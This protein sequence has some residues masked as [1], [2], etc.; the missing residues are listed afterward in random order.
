MRTL[1]IILALVISVNLY[2]QDF[3]ETPETPTRNNKHTSVTTSVSN[4]TSVSD[5]DDTYKFKSKFDVSKKEGITSILEDELDDLKKTKKGN[6]ISWIKYVNGK[7][8]FECKLSKKN[9]YIS[10][11]KNKLSNSFN[12]RIKYLGEELSSFISAH[13]PFKWNSK[14][15]SNSLSSA[16]LRL[17]RAK[18]ELEKSIKNLEKVK[19]TGTN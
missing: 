12:N 7:I 19:R 13:K 3:P 5:S 18:V 16:Q 10:T 11:N 2:A 1:K 4:S 9:L 14:K 15:E 17:E 6:E 8:A